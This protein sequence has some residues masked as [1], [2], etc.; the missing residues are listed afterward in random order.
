MKWRKGVSRTLSDRCGMLALHFLFLKA[1]AFC[2]IWWE[3]SNGLK[4]G[5]RSFLP[6]RWCRTPPPRS[7]IQVRLFR[8]RIGPMRTNISPP[9][10]SEPRK[11]QLQCNT[12]SLAP[13][14]PPF[15][16]PHLPVFLF[17]FHLFR[18]LTA[19]Y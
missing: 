7:P 17:G 12:P 13:P 9:P 4:G 10:K 16:V 1:L 8:S 15:P 18:R 6:Q 5:S 3:R 14:S 19:F 2:G 11:W